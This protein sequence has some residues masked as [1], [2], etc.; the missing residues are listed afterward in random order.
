MASGYIANKICCRSRGP[1]RS[2]CDLC[3]EPSTPGTRRLLIISASTAERQETGRVLPPRSSPRGRNKLR[4]PD[5]LGIV[6]FCSIC[7]KTE[8][9]T[10]SSPRRGVPVREGPF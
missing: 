1:S 3:S 8:S 4:K 2:I 10:L 6:Y 7:L 9:C 5:G